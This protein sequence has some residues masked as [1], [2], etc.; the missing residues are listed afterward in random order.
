MG[1]VV[2]KSRASTSLLTSFLGCPALG[3]PTDE[4]ASVTKPVSLDGEDGSYFFT[5]GNLNAFQ[6]HD[7]GKS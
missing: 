3:V 2:Y 6:E 5:K 1:M 4:R 7:A